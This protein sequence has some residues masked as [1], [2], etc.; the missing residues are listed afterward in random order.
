MRLIRT[1]IIRYVLLAVSISILSAFIQT[2]KRHIINQKNFHSKLEKDTISERL[3][4][5][6]PAAGRLVND[7]PVGKNWVNMLTSLN[8]WNA[9]QKF[10]SLNN[11]MLHGDYSGGQFHNYAWTKKTYKDFELNVL[12]RLDGKEANSGVCI[13][14]EPTDADNAPGYQ[15]DMGTG[16]WGSLWEERRAG[17]VQQ[18]PKE[19][20]E[21]LVKEKDWNHYYIIAKDHH[22]Q[23]WLNEVKTIDTVHA[24]GFDSGAI[25]F[26]LCHGDKHTV[27]DVRTLYIKEL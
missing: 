7:K 20:A 1:L 6:L 23:A 3:K 21:K 13:R 25:G 26:Q 5:S 22:I 24:A 10:W 12:F 14:V 15:V 18:F 8:T 4:K 27:L 9:D 19:A 11:G 16:Y 2:K 17:M